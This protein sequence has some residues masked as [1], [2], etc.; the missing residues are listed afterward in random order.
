[1]WMASLK[2][3]VIIWPLHVSAQHWYWKKFSYT[4]V[5][6]ALVEQR[7]LRNSD[8]ENSAGRGRGVSLTK[9]ETCWGQ[10]WK[11]GIYLIVFCRGLGLPPAHLWLQLRRLWRLPVFY[12]PSQSL[13]VSPD[14]LVGC[15]HCCCFNPTLYVQKV[16]ISTLDLIYEQPDLAK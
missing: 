10:F 14:N 3:K 8:Q 7:C 9:D 1:M 4:H 15:L 6:L 16:S 11:P 13:W 12:L 2:A 5:L